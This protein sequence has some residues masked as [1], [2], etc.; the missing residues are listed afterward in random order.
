MKKNVY[1]KPEIETLKME[2]SQLLN[3]SEVIQTTDDKTGVIL[4]EDGYYMAE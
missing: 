1:V 4:D 2:G 3:T